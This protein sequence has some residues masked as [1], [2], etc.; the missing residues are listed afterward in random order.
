MATF[1][2]TSMSLM[3]RVLLDSLVI[4]TTGTEDKIEG[5]LEVLRPYGL[6]ELVRTGRVG[7]VRGKRSVVVDSADRVAALDTKLDDADT[8][9][10]SVSYSV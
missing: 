8:D 1:G 10:P 3:T 2:P 6:L 9:D 4:E 5:L 7:M